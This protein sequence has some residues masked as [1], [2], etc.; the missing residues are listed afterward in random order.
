MAAVANAKRVF[1]IQL[2]MFVPL[3]RAARLET[4]AALCNRY[5]VCAIQ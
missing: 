1:D 3:F 2:A 4:M 5:Y